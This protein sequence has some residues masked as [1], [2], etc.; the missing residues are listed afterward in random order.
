MTTQQWPDVEP[1]MKTDALEIARKHH[2]HEMFSDPGKEIFLLKGAVWFQSKEDF[3]AFCAEI[4]RRAVPEGWQVVPKEA[5][6]EMQIALRSSGEGGPNVVWK[7][8]L[9]VAPSPK[10]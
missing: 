5:T 8:L 2:M 1:H 3:E 6:E 4:E 9:R 10:E 7:E